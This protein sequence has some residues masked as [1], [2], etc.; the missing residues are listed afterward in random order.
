LSYF[1]LIHAW[2]LGPLGLQSKLG[3]GSAPGFALAYLGVAVL[4]LGLKFLARADGG[5]EGGRR[6]FDKRPS[7]QERAGRS[8]EPA[9]NWNGG[10]RRRRGRRRRDQTGRAAV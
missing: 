10:E 3:P 9:A 2:T 1:G 5:P 7:R 4:A 6:F 8:P